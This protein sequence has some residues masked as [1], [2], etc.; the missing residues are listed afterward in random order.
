MG[1][2]CLSSAQ[3]NFEQELMSSSVSLLLLKTLARSRALFPQIMLETRD[4][5]W[6]CLLLKTLEQTF[7]VS[8]LFCSKHIN[9]FKSLTWLLMFC[10]S[11]CPLKR[12]SCALF[13]QKAQN[14]QHVFWVQVGSKGEPFSAC[15]VPLFSGV[16]SIQKQ[17]RRCHV[18]SASLLAQ[19]NNLRFL[20]SKPPESS[21]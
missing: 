9:T 10:R 20:L 5:V 12:M 19:K 4:V 17:V 21:K 16:I 3:K 13:S 14:S 1:C 6:N 18:L 11:L 2:L 8:F 7:D 15:S